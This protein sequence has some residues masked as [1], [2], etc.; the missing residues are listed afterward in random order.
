MKYNKLITTLLF[1]SMLIL[2]G[3][4]T[5]DKIKESLGIE[6]EAEP[7]PTHEPAPTP[8]PVPAPEPTPEPSSAQVIG[9]TTITTTGG[10]TLRVDRTENG[11]IFEG[12]EGKIVLLEMYGW[13]CPHCIDMIPAYNRFKNKYPNDVYIITLESYGTMDNAAL[14]Q[15]VTNYGIQYDTVSKQ[16]AGN[17]FSFIQ[18]LTGFTVA[19]G[20]PALIVLA[21]DGSMAEYL[22]PQILPEAYVD[23]LIQGLL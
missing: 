21:R 22:P 7:T 18:S 8:E 19:Q 4:G 1:S 23:S 10:K 3:C 11:F 15:F 20:V 2:S 12:Y 17:M 16:N 6:T 14:Q 5:S 13:N 9:S